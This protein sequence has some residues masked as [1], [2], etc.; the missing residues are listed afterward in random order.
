MNNLSPASQWIYSKYK[1][2]QAELQL[3][4][5]SYELGHSVNALYTFLWDNYADWYLEYLKTDE[6]QKQFGIQLF[7][8]F[9]ITLHPYMP[10]ETEA[11]WKEFAEQDTLLAEAVKDTGFLD[12]YSIDEVKV[13][14]FEQII[15]IIEQVR[16]LRGLF[17]VDPLTKLEVVCTNETITK[18]EKY[19]E[20]L[21]RVLII[22]EGNSSYNISVGDIVCGVDILKYI[23]DIQSE[24]QR[25]NKIIQDLERQILQIEGKL[26][27]PGFVT[28][29]TEEVVSEARKNLMDRQNDITS[30]KQKLDMM[31]KVI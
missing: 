25:T 6:T 17:A 18:Y 19:F 12:K 8:D 2:L 5:K 21:G 27:N 10:F 13:V 26:N 11:L 24:I 7:T 20:L 30:Q 22:E 9:I 3:N 28:N 4:L 14:E 31:S 16:S 15:Y 23:P 29:A 1:I